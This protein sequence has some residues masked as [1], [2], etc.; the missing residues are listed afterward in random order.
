MFRRKRYDTLEAI[1]ADVDQWL[2]QDAV[3]NMEGL[4]SLSQ[5]EAIRHV[6]RNIAP[7]NPTDK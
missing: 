1:Q 5:S 2:W 4:Q 6:V 3:A 7:I